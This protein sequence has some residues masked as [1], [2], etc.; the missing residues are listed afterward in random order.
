[1]TEPFSLSALISAKIENSITKQTKAIFPDVTNH[2]ETLFGGTALSWMDEIAFICATRFSR[3]RVVTVSTD[4]IDFKRPIPA[5]KIAELVAKVK[6]VGET[7]LVVG[8]EM[9]TEDMYG[10]S[11]ELAVRGDFTF[12]AID[13]NKKPTK[14]LI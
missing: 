9:F 11:R 14:V 1:M 12:V 8:V 5:G 10:E 2:Y 3:L 7:S 13:E 4:R 6:K